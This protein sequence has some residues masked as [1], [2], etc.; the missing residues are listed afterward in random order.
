[1]AASKLKRV[2]SSALVCLMLTPIVSLATNDAANN[3]TATGNTTTTATDDKADATTNNKTSGTT[4]GA[5]N[6]AIVKEKTGIAFIDK[7]N[8]SSLPTDNITQADVDE[9]LNYLIATQSKRRQ[10]AYEMACEEPEA[11]DTLKS[12]KV[13]D[14]DKVIDGHMFVTEAA[15]YELYCE[16]ETAS[17]IIRCK[18]NGTLIRSTVEDEDAYVRSSQLP[19]FNRITSG[20]T[21]APIKHD[22]ET[23]SRSGKYDKGNAFVSS[24]DA[25][26]TYDAVDN[27]FVA[28][29]N[30]DNHKND[31]SLVGLNIQF[32]VQVTL[33]E[34]GLHVYIP[35]SSI[36]ENFDEE[37]ICYLMGDVYVY[38]LLGYTDR[39][40]TE[41]YMI[42]PDGNGIIVEHED[43]Y[44]DGTA[45][46]KSPYQ[47][48]VYGEDISFAPVVVEDMTKERADLNPVEEV[49]APYFGMVHSY[50]SFNEGSKEKDVAILGIVEEG[51][52]NAIIN[53]SF[54][55][56]NSCF[57]NYTYANIVYREKYEQQTDNAT[58]SSKSEA[59]ELLTG[60]VKVSYVLASGE[61]ANYAGL[62]NKCRDLLLAS[63]ELVKG[64]DLDYD[65]RVDFL[66]LDKENFLL[67]RRN[68]VTTTVENMESIITKLQENGVN[69][70][71]AY[72]DGWQKGGMYNL[73][74]TD[75]KVDSD[76]GGNSA[77]ED[78]VKKYEGSGVSISLIQDVLNINDTTSNST[79]TAAKMINKRTYSYT[80]R[81][82]NVYK[83]FKYLTPSK[84]NE[85]VK[86][87]A[88]NMK[89]GGMT[90]VSLSGFT[91]TLFTYTLNSK[92]YSREVAMEAYTSALDAIIAEGMNV[93]LDQPSMYMWK[94][95]DEFLN[96]PNASSMY[97]YA[98]EE[99]PF[100]SILLKGN[101]KVYSEYV[102]FEANQTEFF[103]KLIETGTYPSFLLTNE[104]PTV[105]QY[106][107][108]SWNYSSEAEKYM[109]V[110]SKFNTE[111]EKV[112]AHTKN[113]YIVNHEMHYDGNTDLT[114]VTY[115]NGSV[116]YINHGEESVSVD[117]VTIDGL[118]Y[119]LGEVGEE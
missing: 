22:G 3:T 1:M 45:K 53:G 111:L 112:N 32:D 36:Q 71:S 47:A 90:N 55:G 30:F 92:P 73:P 105:L 99:I 79:F 89:D 26:I 108:S 115:S 2:L 43:L 57:E 81:F 48:R 106:T 40:D 103:L 88:A 23:D 59:T 84:T 109:N 78:L 24:R 34:Q 19:A 62:A 7:I 28:H 86:E 35:K 14:A 101:M 82:L 15:G 38:P 67:F 29:L 58:G 119:E 51:E 4:T 91:N 87:L 68:V 64:T 13:F 21:I 27:G 113:A 104:S 42:L 97:V 37:K 110:I 74:N 56:V 76:L 33:D 85:Y 61:E 107:N 69:N 114:K 11:D 31:L 16:P 49:I 100:L 44:E 75:Y 25:S 5:A 6:G 10:L 52:Y 95:T 63:G 41:G 12:D 116:V 65:V 18:E 102:N 20:I 80:D 98:S 50:A 9:A 60:D 17:I 72:Y 77:L 46:Y 8:S 93:S 70:I 94:Y 66:G 39:G 54:N 83:T 96:M 117:N 118:D